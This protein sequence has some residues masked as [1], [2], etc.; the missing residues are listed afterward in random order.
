M[1]KILAVAVA[2]SAVALGGASAREMGAAARSNGNVEVIYMNDHADI[3]LFGEKITP[4]RSTE[5]QAQTEIRKDPALRKVLIR[6]DV[7]LK[8]VMAI[9]KSGNGGM[10]V[11]VR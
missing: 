7:Q 9:D 2:M 3:G 6:H 11:Y 8:N 10:I 4:D 5:Q 1:K